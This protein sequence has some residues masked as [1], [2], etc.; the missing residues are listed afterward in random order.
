MATVQDILARKGFDVH[1]IASSETVLDAT[2]MMNDRRV[3]AVVVMDQ[4]NLVGMFTERDVL[5][6]VVAAR[7]DP[8]FTYVGEVMTRDVLCVP[9]NADVDQVSA[10]MKSKRV[11]HLPV[12]SADGDLMGIISIGDINAFYTSNQAH[13]IEWLNEYVF[14]RA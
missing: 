8:Q 10:I 6:R 3:G 12:T 11:R 2:Q 9:P 14:G 13:Q 1:T 5:R 7:R 4:G